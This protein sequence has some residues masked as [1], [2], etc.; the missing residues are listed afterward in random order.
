MARYS[1]SRAKWVTY[2]PKSGEPGL[3]LPDTPTMNG[4][5]WQVSMYQRLSSIQLLDSTTIAPTTPTGL[6]SALYIEG[7]EGLFSAR[8]ACAPMRS[9]ERRVG[10]GC[11]APPDR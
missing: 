11:I 3:R 6:A 2:L 5:A 4:S 8:Y 7:S 10:K 1:G 9:E